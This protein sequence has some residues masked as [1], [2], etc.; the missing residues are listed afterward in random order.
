MLTP[1]LIVLQ[2]GSLFAD[3][4]LVLKVVGLLFIISFVRA[5]VQHVG[6]ST[7][8]IVLMSG[9]LLFDFWKIF[10]GAL[11]LYL[12]SIFGFIH[13]LVDLSF[14]HGFTQPILNIG[15][16]FAKPKPKPTPQMTHGHDPR[17]GMEHEMHEDPR[18]A[19]SPGREPEYEPEGD[20]ESPAARPSPEALRAQYEALMRQ[21]RSRAQPK[22]D[23]KRK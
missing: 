17:M 11:L 8:I 10:G 15:K 22:K 20:Y 2:L 7:L 4:E 6:L 13:I 19:F 21:Q 23:E 14:M 1:L 16:Y 5:H 3:F 18:R 12:I 9:F